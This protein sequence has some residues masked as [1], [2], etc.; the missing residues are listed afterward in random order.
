[1]QLE[2]LASF[3][4][5][6][7]YEAQARRIPVR[8]IPRIISLFKESHKYLI[9]P[10]G[11][12]DPLREIVRKIVWVD[13]FKKGYPLNETFN[14]KLKPDQ[15]PAFSAMMAKSMSILSARTGF[16][17]TVIAAR[18]I[19]ERAVSTLILVKNKT[20]A[21]Q[22][23]KKLSQFLTIEDQPVIEEFT[24]T[25]RKKRKQQIGTYYGNKKNPS[26]LVD[27]ATVQS[28]SS[29]N[30]DQLGSFLNHYGMIISDEV[31][32][33]A[34]YTYDE[35]IRYIY[36]L[37]ATPY[38]GD[39][40]EPIILM[41]FGSIRY[42]TATI[43]PK[44]ALTIKRKVIPRFTNFGMTNLEVLQNGI[45]ENREAILHESQRDKSIIRDANEILAQ[46]RHGIVLTSLI[47]HV[48]QLYQ[49]LPQDKVFRLYGKL[50]VKERQAEIEK[51]N[52]TDGAYII[53]ATTHVAGEGLDI[54]SL[55]TMILAMPVGYREN[56]EQYVGRLN[57]ALNSKKE[58]R[59]YDYV[60]MFVPMLM[61]MYRR[62]KKTYRYLDYEIVNDEFSTQK[63]LQIFEGNYQ[64]ILSKSV[65]SAM[66]LLIIVPVLKPYLR[67]MV[68][69]AVSRGCEV[70]LY[71]QKV[72][73]LSVL[74]N[75]SN[76]HLIK[77]TRELLNYVIVDNCQ[78]WMSSDKNFDY[79]RGMTIRLDHSELI[80]Q[81]R[82]IIART[83]SGFEE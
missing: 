3:R 46:G 73:E 45:V 57:R 55:D 19:A 58:L 47:E 24:K 25:G 2:W 10:R 7:F 66:S 8:N 20:L 80:K 43:D 35:V 1:M 18:M 54:V 69:A 49:A 32:H 79:N 4:N 38:R 29:L 48:D 15:D 44:Y 68:E 11:L 83:M 56:V 71:T 36:G 26:G 27:V 74:L 34:A 40:Q 12:E 16:G 17:K 82:E 61:N 51:I 53:L 60:D 77:Y 67:Q 81:F 52:Q 72:D 9:I 39:G 23:Q 63:G 70:H 31:H 76:F 37:S 59:V 5:P 41:R 64:R 42:Q 6:Q 33:D 22:W 28:I 65:E 21:L 78:L 30:S 62:R 13:K 14:G 50:S 75:N